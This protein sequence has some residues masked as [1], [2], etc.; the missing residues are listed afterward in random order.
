MTPAFI[1]HIVIIVKNIEE[2]EKFYTKFLGSPLELS[3]EQ[4]V[5]KIEETK[6]F[7]GLPYSEWKEIDKDAS[8]LNHLAFGVK[9]AEELR[10]FEKTLNDANI[11]NSGVQIDKWG[12]KEFIWFDDPNRYR[13]EFYCRG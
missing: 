4:V 2:T 1:D 9:T 12:N 8:G 3:K 5:Y 6:I 11:K 10:E 7:F 13:L